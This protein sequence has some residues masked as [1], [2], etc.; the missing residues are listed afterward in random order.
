MIPH[1]CLLTCALVTAQPGDRSAWQLAPHLNQGQ[2]LVYRGTVSEEAHGPGVQFTRSYRLESR[3]LVLEKSPRGYNIAFYTV[4]KLR[5]GGRSDKGL[6]PEP[7]SVRL[8]VVPVDFRGRITSPF[9]LAVPLDGPATAECGAFIEF[10]ADYVSLNKSWETLEDNRPAHIWKLA[11]T[12]TVN[13]TRCL[14]LEGLQQSHDWGQPRADRSAWRRLDKVWLAPDSGVVIK[15]ERVLEKTEPAH[16]EPSQRSVVEYQL[17]D[18]M[19]YRNQLFE[20]RHYEIQMARRMKQELA[21]AVASPAKAS[22]LP[23]DRIVAQIS[24]H[25]Q[26]QPRTPYR[27]ALLQVKRNAEAVKNGEAPP[28]VVR[29]EPLDPIEASVGK[30]APEFVVTNLLTGEL[31][32]SRKWFGHSVVMVFYSPESHMA[33]EILRFAE[34]L[35][36]T[37]H[38]RVNV[39][40]FAIGGDSDKVRRQHTDLKLSFPIL[41]GNGLRKTYA[42]EVTPKLIVVDANGRLQSMYDGW[43][44][45]TPWAVRRDLKQCIQA[46]SRFQSSPEN[47]ATRS[48]SP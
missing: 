39:L 27:D 24:Y 16:Q 3:V 5:T 47:E 42:V 41:S 34:S 43:G 6:D 10:P 26:S 38:Q 2:E 48:P 29:D 32:R 46:D 23:F 12:D 30:R 17:Q 33:E 1:L 37:Y 13:G 22:K 8:E 4:L 15:L 31:A 44:L 21:A 40:G 36:A 14:R 28:A 18:N 35:Q 19:E 20:D 7:S 9:S 25:L 45:E 11:G